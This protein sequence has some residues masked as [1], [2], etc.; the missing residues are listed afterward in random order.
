MGRMN[1]EQMSRFFERT[2]QAVLLTVN[3]DGTPNG[4]PVWF[5][6][7]GEVVRFFTGAD[8][9]KIARIE[10]DP[11]IS[12][13]VV[14]DVDEAPS[15]VRFDGAAVID[16]DADTGA[17]AQMLAERYWD[18]SDP[19]YAAVVEQWHAAPAGSMVTVR[20]EPTRIASSID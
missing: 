17:L 9:K 8:A 4:V 13:L 12:L 7:D 14:N 3:A 1:D 18:L 16:P 5:D 10:Q 19:G 6:W 15:W 2:R 20:V 11:R